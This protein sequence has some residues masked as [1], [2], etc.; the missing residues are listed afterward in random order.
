MLFSK[1][2]L[3]TLTSYIV[4]AKNSGDDEWKNEVSDDSWKAWDDDMFMNNSTTT[5]SNNTSTPTLD[6]FP[7]DFVSG[8]ITN[9]AMKNGKNIKQQLGMFI[10]IG[11]LFN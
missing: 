8:D 4:I 7:T 2:I 10:L 3:F 11:M 1:L 9:N 6:S 5:N